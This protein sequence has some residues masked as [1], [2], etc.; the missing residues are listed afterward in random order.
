MND[1]EADNCTARVGPEV[2]KILEDGVAV[3][4]LTG[5]ELDTAALTKDKFNP[6]HELGLTMLREDVL[7]T[8]KYRLK[9]LS[10][11]IKDLPLLS[12]EFYR[13]IPL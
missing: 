4:P 7:E 10:K 12:L 13:L 11:F 1:S 5:L 9:K 2:E 3:E 6:G 8:K